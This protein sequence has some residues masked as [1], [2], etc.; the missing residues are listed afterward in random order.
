MREKKNKYPFS[1]PIPTY[2]TP[3]IGFDSHIYCFIL[4]HGESLLK[5][6]KAVVSTDRERDNRS[7]TKMWYFLPWRNAEGSL[8]RWFSSSSQKA[9]R[10]MTRIWWKKWR[11]K[12]D[13][14]LKDLVA[15]NATILTTPMWET[16]SLIIIYTKYKFNSN[17]N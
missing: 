6:N 4:Y 10:K 13:G 5:I 3:H 2:Q 7:T 8:L 9:K 1:L 15:M 11:R 17:Q 14:S 16:F 12:I